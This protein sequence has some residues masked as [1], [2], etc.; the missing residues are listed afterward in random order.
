MFNQEIVV[1]LR[2]LALTRTAD[3][4]R[5]RQDVLAQRLPWDYEELIDVAYDFEESSIRIEAL[6]LVALCA[7][8]GSRIVLSDSAQADPDPLVQK[9]AEALLFRAIVNENIHK[10]SSTT[11]H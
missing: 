3:D 11:G 7:R 1:T 6:E 2:A 5:L 4:Y 8:D 9:H 10:F